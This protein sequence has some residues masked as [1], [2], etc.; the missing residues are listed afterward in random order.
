M[1]LDTT[2]RLGARV[3]PL[4]TSCETRC[5]IR[6]NSLT[7]RRNTRHVNRL[8][9]C[10]FWHVILPAGKVSSASARRD[11]VSAGWLKCRLNE[12]S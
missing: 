11:F 5:Q 12:K 7:R 2:A 1:P 6:V 9:A 8:H 4:T 10:S 3:S